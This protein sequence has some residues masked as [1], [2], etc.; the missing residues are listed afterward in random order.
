VDEVRKS[1]MCPGRSRI[2]ICT[3]VLPSAQ[4]NAFQDKWQTELCVMI[5]RDGG[6][7]TE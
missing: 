3:A 1:H 7:W 4:Q 2:Q 6:L 5:W